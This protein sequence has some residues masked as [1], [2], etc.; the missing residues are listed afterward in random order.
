MT[1]SSEKWGTIERE[2]AEPPEVPSRAVQR[3]VGC[4][5]E[6]PATQTNFTLISQRH[7]WRLT[8][9]VDSSGRSFLEWRC[10]ACFARFRSTRK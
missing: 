1:D 9:Q 2:P 6:A 3:C 8:R 10:A 4:R 5:A 7:G